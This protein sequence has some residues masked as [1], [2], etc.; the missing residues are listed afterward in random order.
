MK[1]EI[2][3]PEEA[4][5][6]TK[7]MLE[8]AESS[9]GK[10]AERQAEFER[11]VDEGVDEAMGEIGRK[12][13]DAEDV[14]ERLPF[15]NREH[16][17]GVI[18]RAEAVLNKIRKAAPSLIDDR[19]VALGRLAAAYHDVVQDWEPNEMKDGENVKTMRKRGSGPGVNEAASA[20][21]ALAFMAK[22][23]TVQQELGK[24]PAFT[25]D[26]MKTLAEA[27]D[28]T[29]PGF[30]PEKAT[31]TQ[32]RLRPESSIIARA[33]ALADLGEAGMDSA[34]FLKAGDALFREENLD[35]LEAM[36]DPSKLTEDQKDYFRKRMLGWSKFQPLF[37]RGRQSLLDKELEGLPAEAA[38]EVRSLF[39]EFDKSIDGA[40]EKAARREKMS[41]EETAKDMGYE[42]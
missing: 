42:L 9:E 4:K 24:D 10:E 5:Q 41:F 29:V 33:I 14:R 13:E 28:A 25:E 11:G 19:G 2:P 3:T 37:A 40:A 7:R 16:S 30:N 8:A 26:D 1:F 23:N 39:T 27:I 32:P 17:R 35:I 22:H 31:V 38:D 20:K 34:A 15:H 12:Y 18:A 21:A 6:E 36:K